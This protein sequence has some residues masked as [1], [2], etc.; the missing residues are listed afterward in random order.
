MDIKISVLVGGLVG[1]TVAFGLLWIRNTIHWKNER[2]E[3]FYR[4]E[5]VAE[6]KG[7]KATFLHDGLQTKE[8][9]LKQLKEICEGE[10]EVFTEEETWIEGKENDTKI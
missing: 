7:M 5:K 1:I 6:I 4:G 3:V 10:W 9:F 8:E 2:A